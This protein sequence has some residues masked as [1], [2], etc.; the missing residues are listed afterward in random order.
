MKMDIPLNIL[1]LLQIQFHKVIDSRVKDLM[2]KNGNVYPNLKEY[3]GKETYHAINGMYGGFSYYIEKKGNNYVLYCDSWSR[4][5]GGSG[6]KH[7]ITINSFDLID[8]G[9]V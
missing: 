5:C 6:Q 9:F 4:I 3:N 1:E 2:H 7:K 8:E